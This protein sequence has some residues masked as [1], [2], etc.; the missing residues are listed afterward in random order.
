MTVHAPLT[1]TTPVTPTPP[2]RDL[3]EYALEASLRS[4]MSLAAST[5]P[6]SLQTAIGASEVG[7]A[8][9]RK[10]AYRAAGVTPS[11][12]PDPLRALVGTG[13]HAVMA[14][15]FRALDK[16]SGRYLVER[17]VSYQGTPGTV[18]LYDRLTRTVVDWKTSTKAKVINV[19]RNGP[20]AGHLTQ[21]QVYGAGLAAIG[22]DVAA[23]ALAYVPVD[24]TLDDIYVHRVL[25]DGA[26]AN[27][28]TVRALKVGGEQLMART[29]LDP[30]LVKPTPTKLCPWCPYH[31]PHTRDLSLACDGKE[32]S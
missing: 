1:F 22:E 20:S 16:G 32:S 6:R 30:A 28:A 14:D 17:H 13:V 7:D 11:N 12:L 8:C 4:A 18:D 26:I 24:G 25:Y 15:L 29:T 5:A 19:R 31:Q 2:A 9:Q 3:D 21:I 27:A 10:L 23:V